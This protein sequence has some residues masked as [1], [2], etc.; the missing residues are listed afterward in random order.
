MN[1]KKTDAQLLADELLEP[2]ADC[3]EPS[4][5]EKNA[6]AKL[7]S[8]DAENQQLRKAVA[9]LHAARGRYHTQLAA[10][11][12]YDLVGLPNERPKK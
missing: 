1:T 12:L 2:L 4:L 3:P 11:D 7:L 9:K 6:A 5:V 8:L 10:C